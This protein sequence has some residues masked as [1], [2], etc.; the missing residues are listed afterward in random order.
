MSLYQ[1]I[2]FENHKIYDSEIVSS[3]NALEKYVKM[4]EK[5]VPPEFIIESETQFEFDTMYVKYTDNSG[6]D[7]P[8]MILMVGSFSSEMINAIKIGLK[9]IYNK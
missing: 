8:M 3:Y 2:A 6:D 7:K 5:Y 1:I 9:N 4:C